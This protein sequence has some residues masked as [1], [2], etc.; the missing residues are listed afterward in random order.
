MALRIIKQT[1]DEKV[2]VYY[3]RILKLANYLNHKTNDSL[4]ITLLWTKLVP[5]LQVAIIGMKWDTLFL[6][7]KVMLTCE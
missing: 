3:E 1:P 2:E 6:H 5:Y 7:I 4:F